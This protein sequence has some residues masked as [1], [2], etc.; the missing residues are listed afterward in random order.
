MNKI[1]Y[2]IVKENLSRADICGNSNY[3]KWY[4]PFDS[5]KRIALIPEEGRKDDKGFLLNDIKWNDGKAILC[6]SDENYKDRDF[7]WC[8]NIIRRIEDGYELELYI[9]RVDKTYCKI[10]YKNFLF[11]N[12][13]FTFIW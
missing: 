6:R 7:S 10:N 12:G 1:Q 2:G 8:D 4:K 13:V 5:E 11:V 3:T 9:K